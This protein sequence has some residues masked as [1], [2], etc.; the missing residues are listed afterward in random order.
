VECRNLAE[1]HALLCQ[2]H[3]IEL[4]R[5]LGAATLLVEGSQLHDKSAP[6]RDGATVEVLPPFAGG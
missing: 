4:P 3:Q 5:V 6:L 1:L 2:R